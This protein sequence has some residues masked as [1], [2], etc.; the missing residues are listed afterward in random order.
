MKTS[1]P[2]IEGLRWGTAVT[3]VICLFVLIGRFVKSHVIP[4]FGQMSDHI[5]V[6]GVLA[7]VVGVCALV[8][9]AT[10]IWYSGP[11]E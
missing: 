4:F 1:N 11:L 10:F 9:I 5:G 7:A 8:F 2:L 6:D 3:V